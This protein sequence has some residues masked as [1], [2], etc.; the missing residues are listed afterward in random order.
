MVAYRE[1]Q[2]IA[3]EIYAGDQEREI[4]RLRAEKA[5]LATALK[6]AKGE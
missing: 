1:R 2:L 6:K 3:M 5:L 4:D